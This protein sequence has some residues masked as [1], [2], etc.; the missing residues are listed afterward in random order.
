MVVPT[1]DEADSIRRLLADLQGL[2]V[3]YEVVVADGGSADPTCA[4]A[5]ELGARVL[6]APR[7]RGSQ[8]RAGAAAAIAPLL[9]FLHADVRLDAP[10]LRQIER[11]AELAP[12]G[13]FAFRLAID[14]AGPAYRLVEWGAN[15]RSAWA[16]LPYGDQG[17]LVRRADY[18]AAG[19]YPAVPLMEDVA[20]VRALGRVARV[21]LLPCAIRVSARRW[22]RDGVLRRTWANWR[23]LAAYLLGAPPEQLARRYR[24]GD[25]RGPEPGTGS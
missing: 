15:L 13:A 23:L 16:K 24:S 12:E 21:R 2:A 4:A 10:A 8:L 5:R 1:L 18:D 9:C 7:G 22:E 14:G 6:T 19:G 11:I 25:D 3:S 20:F 17:L